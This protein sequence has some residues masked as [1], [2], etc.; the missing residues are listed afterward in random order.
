MTLLIKLFSAYNSCGQKKPSWRFFMK[1][2]VLPVALSIGLAGALI[3]TGCQ[4]PSSGSGNTSS[5]I[6][7]LTQDFSSDP[8]EPS[9]PEPASGVAAYV[10]DYATN[11]TANTTEETNAAARL[12]SEF[13]DL[14][15]PGGWAQ[16]D[17]SA[18]KNGIIK[19]SSVLS[20]NISYA[21]AVTASRTDE[22][23]EN[24]YYDDR[25][26]KT[27]LTITGFGPLASY[28]Y[29]GSGITTSITSVPSDAETYKY[30]DSGNDYGSITSSSDLYDVIHLIQ[31]VRSNGASSN[32]AKYYFNYARPWRLAND[33]TI[34]EDDS[35]DS[36]GYYADRGYYASDRVT[37]ESFPT[38]SSSVSV[39]PALL[40]ARGTTAAT[41]GGFPSGHTAESY[42]V[43]LIMAYAVPERYQELLTRASD[44]GNNR[45][46]AGMHSP[47]DVMGGRILATAITTAG[48]Y[49]TSY[50]TDKDTAFST[51][52]TYLK[53]QTGTTDSTFYAFAH[54]GTAENDPY[55]DH[56]VN[57]TA[58]L[59]RMTY[60]FSRTGTAGTAAVVPKGAE[61]LLETRFPYL[62]ASQRREVLRTTAIDSGYPLLDDD[63]GWGRLNLFD[64]ADGYGSFDGTV[65]A[66]MDASLVSS[67]QNNFYALDTWRN[68]ISGNGRLVKKGTGTLE[69]SGSNA[70]SGGTNVTGGVLIG[71]SDSAFGTSDVKITS[72][73]LEVDSDSTLTI[74]GWLISTSDG[75]LKL[76]VSGSSSNV[77]RVTGKA[78]LEGTLSLDFD[79]TP[80]GGSKYQLIS[81]GAIDGEFSSVTAVCGSTTLS[82]TVSYTDTGVFIQFQ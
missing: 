42:D 40:P 74:T 38:Y 7:A 24:A 18:Y 44:L 12:L 39:V 67:T 66:D 19:N 59:E 3:L 20:A 22:Q 75:I 4:N 23:A 56:D 55:Y 41:D 71:L 46:F 52:H 28:F 31:D 50:T 27:Y 25:R 45:I 65:Y 8:A 64:A 47:L 14:W 43:G 29:T 68:D 61:V 57:K 69:L 16:S 10:D 63:E 2:Q 51:A 81:A 53:N 54:S 49:N 1:R 33:S 5:R 26:G 77:L 30:D 13:D 80:A 11:Q 76:D 48:L 72:G 60:G 17:S 78:E 82:G 79:A 32:P 21:A 9:Y 58:Y 70:Y 34:T 15:T 36:D 35:K 6:S 73:T 62:S 37:E